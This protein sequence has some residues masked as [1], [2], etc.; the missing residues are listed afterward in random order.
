MLIIKFLTGVWNF[1]RRQGLRLRKGAGVLPVRRARID[2]RVTQQED[3]IT[4]QD[5]PITRTEVALTR[6][7]HA[8][9]RLVSHLTTKCEKLEAEIQK[10]IKAA[11][12]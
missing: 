8:A 9:W 7:L 5:D 1:V 11:K 2:S 3:K 12:S 10:W 4:T 6:D